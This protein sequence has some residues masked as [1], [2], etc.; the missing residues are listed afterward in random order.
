MSAIVSWPMAGA[1]GGAL[2]GMGVRPAA[3]SQ[4]AVSM[5]A[6]VAGA[7]E[8]PTACATL[9]AASGVGGD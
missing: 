7:A 8:A 4:G 9:P 2:L 6:G 1:T 5:P 3:E